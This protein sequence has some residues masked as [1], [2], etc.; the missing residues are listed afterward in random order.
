MLKY[1]MEESWVT[2]KPELCE[3]VQYG[4]NP[5]TSCGRRAGALASDG[6]AA[7][8]GGVATGRFTV[9]VVP[10]AAVSAA[11]AALPSISALPSLPW[12]AATFGGLT[13]DPPKLV[14]S[15]TTKVTR[16]TVSAPTTDA[17]V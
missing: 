3:S 4:A 5:N 16:R 14:D 12:L 11:V 9:G 17:I 10:G 8:G 2:S 1:A 15:A 7:T 6:G 13:D